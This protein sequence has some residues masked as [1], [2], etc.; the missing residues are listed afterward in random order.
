MVLNMPKTEGLKELLQK[1]SE[2][3]IEFI[4]VGG[5]AAVLHGAP[6]T[7]QDIDI[8][9]KRT[10]QN[11]HKLLDLLR[12][13][14]ASYR[15]QPKGRK[16]FPTAKSL[17][18]K[19]HHNLK[20]RLGPMD[21]LCELEL[22]QGF[23]QL[24]PFTTRFSYGDISISVVELPKLIELKKMTGRAKDRLML[25]ILVSIAKRNEGRG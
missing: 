10:E 3:E 8:V 16:L 5:M 13:L 4:L 1:L 14:D 24:E 15:G 7:T 22:D 19:G 25:P 6:V 11:V 21:L 18:G 20:T 9:H 12:E 23:E 2:N 17:L